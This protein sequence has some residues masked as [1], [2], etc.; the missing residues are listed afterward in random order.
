MLRG[1]TFL[2]NMIVA[3]TPEI[4]G[5]V[6]AI[7]IGLRIVFPYFGVPTWIFGSLMLT[8]ASVFPSGTFFFSFACTSGSGAV[9]NGRW[10]EF[11]TVSSWF[12]SACFLV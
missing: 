6:A 7:I 10:F 2:S 8:L 4:G 9:P 3:T 12:F 11:H 1:P 5:F